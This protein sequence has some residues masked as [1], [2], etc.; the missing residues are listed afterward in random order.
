MKNLID[1]KK[2][3]GLCATD[4]KNLGAYS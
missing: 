1:S 2:V 3:G 4:R